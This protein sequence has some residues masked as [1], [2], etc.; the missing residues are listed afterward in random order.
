MFY[1]AK[2]FEAIGVADVGY[3]IYVGIVQ[4]ATMAEEIVLTLIGVGVFFLGRALE[5]KI[6]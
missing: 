2:I 4:H 5:N 1:L 6:T 3:A